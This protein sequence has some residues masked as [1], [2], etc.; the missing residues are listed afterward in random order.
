MKW[1]K[2]DHWLFCLYIFYFVFIVMYIEYI[3]CIHSNNLFHKLLNARMNS[4]MGG[5]GL[6]QTKQKLFKISSFMLCITILLSKEREREKRDKTVNLWSGYFC[7]TYLQA[8]TL[9]QMVFGPSSVISSSI[10]VLKYFSTKC[11]HLD[12]SG[13]A[14]SQVLFSLVLISSWGKLCH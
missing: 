10:R 5:S 13:P 7:C 1:K 3:K 4:F 11:L 12:F 6:E 2:T 14:F 9:V 8:W